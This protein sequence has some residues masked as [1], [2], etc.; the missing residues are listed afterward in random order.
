LATKE[1]A[2]ASLELTVSH[3]LFTGKFFTKT[4]VT[5]VPH[6]PYFSLVPRLK[7]KLKG[8]H[9]DTTEVMEAESRAVLNTLTEH[10]L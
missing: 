3:F 7:I 10:D 8:R 5:V 6:L 9:F 4:N 1:L 2:V